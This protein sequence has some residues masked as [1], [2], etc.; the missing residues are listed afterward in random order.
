MASVSTPAPRLGT[1]ALDA[2][3]PLAPFYDDFT[4]T[5]AHEEWLAELERVARH[6]GAS[7]Q[8]LFDVGCGTGKS[9]LP[10][11]NRGYEVTACD[12]SPAMVR[13]AR[14]RLALPAKR[15]LVADMRSLPAIGPFDLALCL[16]DAFNYLLSTAD[17]EAAFSS[18]GKTLRAGGLLVFDVNTIATYAVVFGR[19]FW[20]HG[21]TAS[22]H[23]RGQA[24]LPPQPG[25]LFSAEIDVI[26]DGRPVG[27]SVHRQRHHS[28]E[29][30][31]TALRRC[32]L[33]HLATFGQSSGGR[34][35]DSSDELSDVKLVYVVRR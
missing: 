35:S 6:H 12:V 2:Y 27:I 4:A 28:P 16:D 3:E 18:I 1:A 13:L 23:W 26:R 5:Y 34:L 32:G 17:L 14:E 21:E 25:G 29:V 10:L 31:E 7:G 33:T 11:Q 20:R 15:C 9:S 30:I 22:Y 19:D 8:R 24:Q